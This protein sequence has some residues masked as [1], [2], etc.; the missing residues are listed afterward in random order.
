MIAPDNKVA[1]PIVLARDRVEYGFA[2][3]GIAHC[4]WEGG[5]QHA[6]L[7]VIIVEERA[8]TPH[9]DARRDIVVFRFPNKRM[10]KEAIDCLERRFPYVLV[11]AM[12]RISGLKSDNRAPL[13]FGER[14]ARV[15]GI[16]RE[17]GKCG[18]YAVNEPD[19]PADDVA[20]PR[21]SAGSWRGRSQS[22]PRPQG[23]RCRG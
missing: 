21:S 9:P 14:C 4:R 22:A 13:S 3:T 10:Q 5:Q 7:W 17:L 16:E 1:A 6:T 23:A 19:L 2:R 12:H 20:T 15:S 18:M 11:R 8:I